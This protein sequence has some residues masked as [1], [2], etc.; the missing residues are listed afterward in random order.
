MAVIHRVE[1]TGAAVAL[2]DLL[3]GTARR[4]PVV[5][6]TIPAGRE[7]PWI[8]VEDIAREAGDLAEVYLMPTG[9]FSWDFS[10]RMAEGTQVYGGAGRVYPLGHEWSSDLS[11]SPLRFA[12]N[13]SDGERATN[14]LISDMLRMAAGLVQPRTSRPLRQ[15]TGTVK[16]LVAGRA[17]VDVG[18]T[19][20][21][22]VAE[23]LTV[24]GVA[25]DHADRRSAR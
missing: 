24:P 11:K 10:R 3:N 12:F 8:D 15:V 17:L 22:A 4:R 19:F 20:L 13:A 1:G 23:E 21:A 25:I 18:N 16:G 14:L 9:G 7:E 5:V 2:A 6:V